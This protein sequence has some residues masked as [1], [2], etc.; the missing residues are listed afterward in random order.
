[1]RNFFF[2]LKIRFLIFNYLKIQFKN[3]KN[4]FKINFNNN[5]RVIIE[6]KRYNIKFIKI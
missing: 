4:N 3:F 1:M 2:S 5:F 6:I